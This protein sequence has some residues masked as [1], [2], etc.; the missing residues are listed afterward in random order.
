[1]TLFKT[2]AAIP[3]L[4][5]AC[6]LHWLWNCYFPLLPSQISEFNASHLLPLPF[7][8]SAYHSADVK[9]PSNSIQEDPHEDLEAE[10]IFFQ[11]LLYGQEHCSC[12][13]FQVA[14][15]W[16]SAPCSS[17]SKVLSG[18]ILN[19]V[20]QG[21]DLAAPVSWEEAA[22]SDLCSLG[23]ALVA[24]AVETT[25]HEYH[26]STLSLQELETTELGFCMVSVL[27]LKL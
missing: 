10:K 15:Q 13:A 14:F 12:K 16:V 25:H 18:L 11:L 6:S 24:T 9:N 7:Q 2:K 5:W 8:F 17:E 21:W 20:R 23:E 19:S 4:F 1:M 27:M 22:P 3:S 26:D